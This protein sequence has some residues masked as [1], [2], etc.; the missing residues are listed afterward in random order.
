M[1]TILKTGLSVLLLFGANPRV[2][3]VNGFLVPFSSVTNNPSSSSSG[4]SSTNYQVKKNAGR[5]YQKAPVLDNWKVL[6]N[7]S[8]VGT[9]RNHPMI[10]DGDVI[11]T[12]PLSDPQSAK[13]RSTVTT[14]S[15]SKY[16][17]GFPLLDDDEDIVVDEEQLQRQLTKTENK[18]NDVKKSK[19]ELGLTGQVIG[20]EQSQHKYLL[21]G[22]PQKSTSG[23]SKIYTCYQQSPHSEDH[24]DESL[25]VKITANL[26]ALQREA[27]NYLAISSSKPFVKLIEYIPK[28]GDTKHFQQKSALVM[29]RGDCDLKAYLHNNYHHLLEGK[30]L[31]TA[32]KAALDCLR[33]LHMAKMVWTDLKTENLIVKTLEDGRVIFKGIDLESAMPYQQYPV[34]YSPEACP[35]EFAIAFLDGEY[36][37]FVLD[38]SYDIWSLGMV[39]F[40]LGTGTSMLE[41]LSP[42]EAT[43]TLANTDDFFATL[44][45][46][47]E[48]VE[49]ENLRDLIRT[50]LQK[51][52]KKRPKVYQL[53][54]HPLFLKTG[55]GWFQN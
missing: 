18:K 34:D 42:L 17:L 7:G 41:G 37:D 3:V 49:D 22:R 33:S 31:Q 53:Y 4:S 1:R 32:A 29:E 12:S 36:A 25:I 5:L 14:Q 13:E 26:E 24:E 40:E 2:D 54:F 23:K 16:K 48:Q 45:S 51:D 20:H 15:G 21:A 50:C 55:F 46:H 39:L 38:Y 44:E 47:L 10:D 9:V 52:P 19:L 43:Q 8:V 27:H 30:Q 28:A 35:P 6:D 11:A